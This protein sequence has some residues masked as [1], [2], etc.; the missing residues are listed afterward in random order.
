[1]PWTCRE[2]NNPR[3]SIYWALCPHYL[4]TECH[5]L[6]TPSYF[7]FSFV[8]VLIFSFL[9][10]L[11]SRFTISKPD[12][13][14]CLWLQS[15]VFLIMSVICDLYSVFWGERMRKL[16]SNLI[17]KL[18]PQ[19]NPLERGWCALTSLPLFTV[20]FL[21]ACA[22][23]FNAIPRPFPGFHLLLWSLRQAVDGKTDQSSWNQGACCTVW[24]EMKSF[25][26]CQEAAS[27]TN[28]A[29]RCAWL[30]SAKTAC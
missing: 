25:C 19:G 27:S 28:A 7:G 5:L 9:I 21:S 16:C 4:A 20:H 26:Y 23:L 6:T 18:D 10:Q 29:W 2:K 14:T 13:L 8:K 11:F 3:K 30:L 17:T 22:L 15:A 1:M 24:E 12:Y